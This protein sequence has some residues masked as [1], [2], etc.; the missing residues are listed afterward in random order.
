VSGRTYDISE[1]ADDIDGHFWE[2]EGPAAVVRALDSGLPIIDI[3]GHRLGP[4]VSRPPKIV[5]IGFNYLAHVTD[6]G[7]EVPPEPVIFMKPS[8]TAVG[9]HD[10]I[11]IPPGSTKTDYEGELGVIIGARCRYLD[12][13]ESATSAIAGYLVS[14][15]VSERESQLEHGG[16]WVKGK[17]S[18]NFNPLGPYLVTADEVPDPQDLD[19]ELHVNGVL[20]QQTSTS[21][22]IFPVMYLVWYL[23]QFMVLE[24]GDLINTGT[25]GGVGKS[26]NPPAFLRAGDRVDLRIAGLGTQSQL[27]EQATR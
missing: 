22:M 21:D 12:S 5:G 11:L 10:P 16:Q 3:D 6:L 17:A 14:N 1:V 23:S 7:A 25:P 13:P 26:M 2:S 18:E 15:D 27:C 4:P 20:R 19:L 9:P 8:N 24:A